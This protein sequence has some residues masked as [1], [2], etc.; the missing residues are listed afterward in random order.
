MWGKS[1][2]VVDIF[3][4]AGGISI[5]AKIVGI[6]HVMAVE[7]DRHSVI[8]YKTNHPKIADKVLQKD[9][10]EVKSGIKGTSKDYLGQIKDM[11]DLFILPNKG[12]YK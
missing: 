7:F 10:R 8:T 4:G 11:F 5:G 3:N 12:V 1:F 9:N 2:T 6:T